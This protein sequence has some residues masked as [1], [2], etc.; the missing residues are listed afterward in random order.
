M[1]LGSE[2]AKILCLD[3]GMQRRVKNTQKEQPVKWEENHKDVGGGHEAQECWDTL[4]LEKPK[5]NKNPWFVVLVL[6]C[7]KTPTLAEPSY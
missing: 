5:Q 3:G 7:V 4:S 6:F 2:Q 1:V